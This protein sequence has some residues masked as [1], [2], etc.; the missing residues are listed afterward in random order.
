M[1][2]LL[3]LKSA[4]NNFKKYKYCLTHRPTI[5]LQQI[6]EEYCWGK[7]KESFLGIHTENHFEMHQKST[8]AWD[9]HLKKRSRNYLFYKRLNNL[10][11]YFSLN[12]YSFNLLL[13]LTFFISMHVQLRFTQAVPWSME[14][15]L[16]FAKILFTGVSSLFYLVNEN[17]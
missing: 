6:L 10:N 8:K 9:H 13:L 4:K 7:R 5:R 12:T 14:I 15:A 3:K 11:I 2:V 1:E 17:N 16:L